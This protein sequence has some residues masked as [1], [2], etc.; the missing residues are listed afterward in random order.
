MTYHG[1][2]ESLF[3]TLTCA[4]MGS[5]TKEQ[6]WALQAPTT[7]AKTMMCPNSKTGSI[8]LPKRMKNK[9]K[10]QYRQFR[11]CRKGKLHLP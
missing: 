4:K 5:E 2:V 8:A 1:R 10:R 6:Q 3:K 9:L 7:T 11:E